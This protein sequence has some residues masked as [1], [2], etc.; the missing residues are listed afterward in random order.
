MAVSPANFIGV[1]YLQLNGFIS[2]FW[3]I[4]TGNSFCVKGVLCEI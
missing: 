1:H 4:C 2:K 3:P